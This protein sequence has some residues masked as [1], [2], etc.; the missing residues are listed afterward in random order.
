MRDA[1]RRLDDLLLARAT[2][3]LTAAERVELERLLE[4]HPGV[5]SERYEPAA[6]AVWL[7]TLDLS[8]PLPERVRA[9]LEK[10]AAEIFER[11]A[12]E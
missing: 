7:A 4:A 12:N 8:E 2:S 5:D 3:G 10:R 1:F 11:P 9:K 6:A